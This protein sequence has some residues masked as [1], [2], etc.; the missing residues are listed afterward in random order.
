MPCPSRSRR[1]ASFVRYAAHATSSAQN[2]SFAPGRQALAPL[3]LGWALAVCVLA[4]VPADVQAAA[5]YGGGGQ[6]GTGSGSGA[7]GGQGG[8]LT[9]GDGGHGG[10]NILGLPVNQGYQAGAGGGAPGLAAVAGGLPGTSGNDGLPG[11]GGLGGAAGAPS[12]GGQLGGGGGG[13]GLTIGSGGGGGSD[14]SNNT[15]ATGGNGGDSSPSTYLLA[16]SSGAINGARGVDALRL[17]GGGGGGAAVVGLPGVSL[18]TNGSA[19]IQGGQGGGSFYEFTLGQ[20]YSAAGGGG[21]GAGVVAASGTLQLLGGS[22]YG[23]SGGQSR[24][25]GGAG[26]DAIV[27]TSGT[28]TIGPSAFVA[29]GLGGSVQSASATGLLAG[30]GGTGVS[31]GSGTVTNEGLIAGGGGGAAG[32]TDRPGL[33]GAALRAGSNTTV[34]NKGTMSSGTDAVIFEGNNNT[35]TLWRGATTTGNI[36]FTGTGN[37][38]AIGSN[39][40]TGTALARVT[41][42][43]DF[44]TGGTFVVRM[45][46]GQADLLATTGSANVSGATV[47]VVAGSGSYGTGTLYPILQANGTLNGTRFASVTT[48]LAYLD[49]ALDYSANDQTVNLKFATKQVPPVTPDPD[50]GTP[51]ATGGNPVPPVIEPPATRPIRFADLV[52]SRNGIATANAVNSLPVSHEVYRHALTLPEGAPPSYF[53]ALSGETHASAASALQGLGSLVRNVPLAQL[54]ANLGAGLR[55]GAPTAAAGMSD[56]APAAATLPTSSAQPAW[57]QVVGNWQRLGATADTSAVRLHTGG[58]FA[59][60]DGAIGSG[61]RLGGA[62]GY[63]DSNLRTDGV[64]AK[65]D[66]SSYSAIVYGGKA[67]AAGPGTLNLLLGAAYTWHDISTQRRIA[68]GG[69]DQTLRADYGANTTQVFTELGWALKASDA[70]TLEPYAGA[71]WA[72][73]RSRAFRESGGSAALSGESQ[74]THTTTTTLGLRAR[75][76]LALGTTQGALTGGLGWRHA[77]GDIKP[78]ARMAFDAGDAFTVAGAPIARNAALVEVGLDAAVGRNATV[79]LAYA[80]QF[81]S[82]N[83]DHGAT[84]SWRWAF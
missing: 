73:Q 15:L 50:P 36:R 6:A 46:N 64:D 48:N 8:G 54:R 79:G 20:T 43:V 61:W 82:G 29:G 76:D 23:G 45:E 1:S 70:L 40:G 38:L 69:L 78:V 72:G 34:I 41:G 80:G 47:K 39:A 14:G 16:I 74:T 12:A 59:G 42:S 11:K 30:N 22:I 52:F 13:G 21:G 19:I 53:A 35:L 49:T 65:T 84:L 32:P 62:L 75:H 63:T 9:G 26:G 3:A 56:A 28:I 5:G 2:A 33:D 18:T 71:A 31:I 7:G 66:I 44:G 57:V 60:G 58:V 27:L 67:F 10:G 51:P 4:A 68:A 55:P 25:A 81:G 24:I 17:G 77:F 83:Q 37:T